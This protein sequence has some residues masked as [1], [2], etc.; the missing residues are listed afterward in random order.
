MANGINGEIDTKQLL[1]ALEKLPINIQKNV[2]V[3]A[4]RASAKVVS[5][6]AKRLVPI[7]NGRLKKSIGVIKR[8]T[9]KGI[10]TFSVSPRKGG[11]SD[12]FYGRFIELGT[13]KMIAKPFLRPA[14]EKSVDETL[15]ASKKYIQERLP[16]EVAKARK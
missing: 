8:K 16:K 14:L 4:T 5:D 2:M 11:K 7:D 6:E 10:T 15:K 9:R 1:R 12:A 3:G 13:S